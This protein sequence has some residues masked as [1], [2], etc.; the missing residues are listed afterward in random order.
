MLAKSV[1]SR[2]ITV[3]IVFALLIGLGFFSLANLP[4]D[5]YP[6]INPPYLVVFTSFPGAGP[7]EVERSVTRPLEAALTGV[8]GIE[9]V[10]STSSSGTSMVIL[11]FTYGTD[12]ADS[13]LSVRD[14]LDRIRRILPSTANTPTIFKFDP[15]M[16]PIMG[17]RVT[18]NRTPEE[19]RE[20]VEDT[21]IPRIEQ[22][23]GI[24]TASVSGGREKVIRVEIPQNR[25]EAYG[26][27]ITQIQ[28]VLA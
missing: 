22:T 27:T 21:I 13:S 19:L 7:E 9:K 28:Q 17:L 15:S 25:L 16:I 14:A 10:T 2:P 18:G 24:A 8:S 1:V 23:P 12:L 5:L 11:Q 20:M 4:I 3:F 26:L 6:E